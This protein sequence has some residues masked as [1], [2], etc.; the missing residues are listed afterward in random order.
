MNSPDR[1]CGAKPAATARAPRVPTDTP[2]VATP[3]ELAKIRSHLGA[4]EDSLSA[5]FG[6]PYRRGPESDRWRRDAADL[7]ERHFDAIVE[8]WTAAIRDIF[9]GGSIPQNRQLT[10]NCANALIRFMEHLRNRDDLSTYVHLRRHCQEGMLSRVKP[11]E[12]NVLHIALKQIILKRVRRSLRGLRME[13]AREAVVAALDERRLMVAQFYIE[14]RERA[15]R[16][17]EEK[18]RN[19][20]NHA[21]DPMYELEPDTWTVLGANAAAEELHRT[22]DGQETPPIVGRRLHEL[23]PPEERQHVLHHMQ[24]VLQDGSDQIFD[25]PMAG[26]YFD[27]NSALITYGNQKFVHLILHDVTQRREMLDELLRA[28]RLAAA[29]TFA[30]GVAHEVNNP[31]GSI[32]S[33]VQSLLADETNSARRTTLHTILAQIT[34]ISSTL[35]NLVNFA[36]PAPAQRGQLDI[37]GLVTETL[38]LVAYNNRF[39]GIAFEPQLDSG[40]K[41]AFADRNEIQQVLINLLFNAADATQREGGTIRIHTENQ[42]GRDNSRA[43]RRVVMRVADNGIGIP[44]E[45]LNRVFDPFFTTKPAGSGV[46]LGLS[47]CQRIILANR[48]TVRIDS[49]VGRGTSVTICL[50]VF[51]PEAQTAGASAR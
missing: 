6:S 38:R 8:E 20:I 2:I 37:N 7:I 16:V 48:G 14:S 29:G 41:A 46:G 3:E 25:W 33:L 43:I 45:H 39:H 40:L 28:E 4:I 36:R 21:P 11:S 23:G 30:A 9:G 5:L 31:L 12:F 17:S 34:R 15:L 44:P 1:S 19:S 32:S 47:L 10:P 18:Y 50:P 13:R 24:K 27:V 49:E 22:V 26:R 42:A 35:K 51:E